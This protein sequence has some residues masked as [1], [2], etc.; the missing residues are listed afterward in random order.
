MATVIRE[1]CPNCSVVGIVTYKEKIISEVLVNTF[2]EIKDATTV[3]TVEIGGEQVTIS[4][5]A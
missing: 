4:L 3:N 2:G 5:K 1:D